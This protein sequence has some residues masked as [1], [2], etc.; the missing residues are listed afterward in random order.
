MVESGVLAVAGGVFGLALAWLGIRALRP[1]MP[2]TVPRA[3]D[4]GLD[5]VCPRFHRRDD[6]RRRPA[7][8]C[9]AGVARDETEPA[10]RSA[11]RR[12]Q[13]HDQPALALAVGRDGRVGSGDRAGAR[14]RRRPSVPKLRAADVGRSGVPHVERRGVPRGAAGRALPRRPAEAS[15][16]R[17]PADADARRAGLRAGD[18]RFGAADEPAG[19]AVRAQLHDRRARGRVAVRTAARARTAA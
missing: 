9:C 7:V 2:P 17:R 3:D 19:R 6:H 13:Q 12:T 10:R 15:V 4:I 8:R 18:G 14:H 5:R 16:L 1:L 11:G